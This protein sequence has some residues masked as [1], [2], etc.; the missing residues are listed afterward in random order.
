MNQKQTTIRA[1]NFLTLVVIFGLSTITGYS[2]SQLTATSDKHPPANKQTST[3]TAE[4]IADIRGVLPFVRNSWYQPSTTATKPTDQ[5]QPNSFSSTGASS[6]ISSSP[7]SLTNINNYIVPIVPEPVTA[8]PINGMAPV[9]YAI[10]TKQPVVFLTIDDGIVK[11]PTAIAFIK[12]HH[13]VASLFLNDS[14]V[15]DNYSYF[16]TLKTSGSTIE[17][18]TV[19]HPDLTRLSYVQQKKEICD[20]ADR[21]AAVFGKRPT[22]FRPPYG[23]FNN[24][25]R[26][27][28]ADC[29]MLALIHWHAKANN[30]AMQY[31]QGDTLQP[32]DI[33]LMHF[34]KDVIADLTAFNEAAQKSN[35]K[36]VLL[37]DWIK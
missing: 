10:E 2:I 15:A 11:D 14:K 17:N 22:L 24:T 20:N 35:L 29:G 12:R 6:Q 37:E 9:F 3:L 18:H 36:T 31:Q 34:R 4:T 8:V 19:N 5:N 27:A 21:F 1:A 13:L 32:G 23:A 25:T 7:S 28:A 16:K 33:V 30:G 26:R